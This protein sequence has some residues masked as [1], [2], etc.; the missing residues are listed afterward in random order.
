MACKMRRAR[1]ARGAFPPPSGWEK[2]LGEL[3]CEILWGIQAPLAGSQS[4]QGDGGSKP[5]LEQPLVGGGVVEC[6]KPLMRLGKLTRGPGQRQMVVIQTSLNIKMGPSRI[7]P[8]EV[9]LRLR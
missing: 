8:G 2:G 7:P 1:V 4:V 9:F 6:E 3:A 5:L